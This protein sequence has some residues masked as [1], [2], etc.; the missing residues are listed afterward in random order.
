MAEKWPGIPDFGK[1]PQI[2]WYVFAVKDTESVPY[3]TYRKYGV[4]VLYKKQKKWNIPIPNYQSSEYDT[5]VCSSIKVK[6]LSYSVSPEVPL[7]R[8]TADLTYC[9][10]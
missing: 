9:G 3:R 5:S 2:Y 7:E 10:Y 8:N 4:G 6:P 1:N